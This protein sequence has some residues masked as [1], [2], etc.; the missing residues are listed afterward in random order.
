MAGDGQ[1]WWKGRGL[2]G[3]NL[4]AFLAVRLLPFVLL[5]AF[6]SEAA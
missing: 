1:E 3:S 6:L 4:L 5:P 2:F